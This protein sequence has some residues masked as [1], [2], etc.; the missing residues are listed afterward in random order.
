[1]NCA[2]IK[3]YNEYENAPEAKQ[4]KVPVVK[5]VSITPGK[6]KFGTNYEP[7]LRIINWVDRPAA[8]PNPEPAKPT[9][10]AP[11]PFDLD[12]D[13]EIPDFGGDANPNA[14]KDEPE[15]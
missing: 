10:K 7:D 4:G 14:K 8:L 15:W 1:M 2:I 12:L 6:S 13:D 11:A 5:C 3:L 9:T